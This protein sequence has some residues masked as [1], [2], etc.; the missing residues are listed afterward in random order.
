MSIPHHVNKWETT[1]HVILNVVER[2]EESK[3]ERWRFLVPLG[4]T[5]CECEEGTK[6]GSKHRK[7]PVESA[8]S[9]VELRHPQG[10]S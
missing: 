3:A 1:V 7:H 9:V 4:M 6:G 5:W 10:R 2:S 8:K